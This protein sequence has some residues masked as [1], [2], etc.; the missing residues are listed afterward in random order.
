VSAGAC[1]DEVDDLEA[2]GA[3]EVAALLDVGVLVDDAG[4]SGAKSAAAHGSRLSAMYFSSLSS[5]APPAAGCAQT[6]PHL[7]IA[8]A[9]EVS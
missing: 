1:Q 9:S 2:V 6:G 5:P 4:L 8:R 7:A 3:L